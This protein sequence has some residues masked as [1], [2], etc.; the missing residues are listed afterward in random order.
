MSVIKRKVKD[1][2]LYDTHTE[3]IFIN[4]YM[5]Q[6]KG[7]Y[8]KVY[9]YASMYAQFGMDLDSDT[10]AEQLKISKEKVG[11]AWAYWEKMGL[12]KRSFFSDEAT[13]EKIEFLNIKDMMYR[14]VNSG[15]AKDDLTGNAV[16]NDEN[17]GLMFEK[18]EKTMQR[19]LSSTEILKINEFIMDRKIPP[20]VI[21]F[22]I[23]YCKQ[24]GK[25][26]FR[27]ISKVIKS[28]NDKGL[29]SIDRIRDYLEEN[30]RRHVQY[31]RVLKA[32]GFSRN[33]TEKEQEMMN[34]WFDEYGY[35]MD[36]V[37]EAVAKTS[38]IATP[39]FNYVNKVLENWKRESEKRGINDVNRHAGVSEA[40][41]HEYYLYLQEKAKQDAEK[42]TEYVYEVL[43]QIKEIDD[44]LTEIRR[45]LVQNMLSGKN[46]DFS[47]INSAKERLELE[48]AGVLTDGNFDSDYTEVKYLCDKC[49]DTGITDMNEVCDCRVE[50][51]D[52][53]EIWLKQKTEE[54]RSG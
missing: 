13:G 26:S 24:K 27:Y 18:V 36:R 14:T 40:Q 9:M 19:Q 45:K 53:A 21:F 23:E 34:R 4:E 22:A 15:E 6:A 42:R 37:L 16:F 28:W 11:E 17:L 41:L 33:A 50:R 46:G 39:N 3:N 43:P 38:G 12:V 49:R 5:P 2:Y 51:L 48:R 35:G 8:V 32:L 7:D 54:K 20:E 30:D 10:I 47:S 44:K 25:D 52:E 1:L 29:D 31:R